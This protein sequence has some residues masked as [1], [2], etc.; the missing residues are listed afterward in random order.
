MIPQTGFEQTGTWSTPEREETLL[1]ELQSRGLKVIASGN[2]VLGAPIRGCYL[3]NPA[4]TTMLIQ[5]GVHGN[6]PSGREAALTLLRDLTCAPTA[7]QSQWL[8]SHRL[9][10]IPNANPD[11]SVP[12]RTR[13][14]ALD[15]NLNRDL[16]QLTMPESRATAAI[17]QA[18]QPL[19]SVDLHE[20]NPSSVDFKYRPSTMAGDLS[21]A[22][23]EA[24]ASRVAGSLAGKGWSTGPYT[25]LPQWGTFAGYAGMHHAVS[26]LF[27]VGMQLTFQ[28]RLRVLRDAVEEAM[29][30]FDENRVGLVSAKAS[31]VLEAETTDAPILLPAGDAIS[32]DTPTVGVGVY[33]APEHLTELFE[34]HGIVVVDGMASTQQAARA[35]IVALLDPDSTQYVVGSPYWHETP[36]SGALGGWLDLWVPCSDGSRHP[37]K[38]IWVNHGGHRKKVKD[39]WTRSGNDRVKVG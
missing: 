19:L 1:A 8:A 15:V 31:S 12:P 35:F 9:V 2:S 36:D 4:G 22:L 33:P 37:V 25:T 21:D 39:M 11:G 17:F 7:A 16:L 3:G 18:A 26:I 29:V 30:W 24:L 14:N 27:E 34:L 38:E 23:G 32:G 13:G 28:D 10:V 6:E 20:M 5:G